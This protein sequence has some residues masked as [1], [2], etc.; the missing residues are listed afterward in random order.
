MGP[1]RVYA[2]KLIDDY[3]REIKTILDC[4]DYNSYMKV[5]KYI[6]RIKN[7]FYRDELLDKFLFVCSLEDCDEF[8]PLLNQV[9]IIDYVHD[10]F[11]FH[12][13]FRMK[14]IGYTVDFLERFDCQGEYIFHN[15]GEL[16]IKMETEFLTKT[17]K[18][19]VLGVVVLTMPL[20]TAAKLQAANPETTLLI[21]PD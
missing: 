11:I 16:E 5:A 14:I 7:P 10:N 20:Q 17:M 13:D 9:D 3:I 19:I 21:F 15:M 2:P 12:E 8:K 1:N 4:D 6:S 18:A